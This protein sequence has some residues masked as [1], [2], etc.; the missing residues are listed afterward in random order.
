MKKCIK[1]VGV[2]ILTGIMALSAF[3]FGG[4]DFNSVKDTVKDT[5][6]DITDSITNTENESVKPSYDGTVLTAGETYDFGASPKM[7]F[8]SAVMPMSDETGTETQ[9][10]ETISV[11]VKATVTP[12]D[13]NQNVSWR[14]AF[15]NPE[16]EWA[17][18]KTVTDY[19]EVTPTYE[20]ST[21]ATLSCK[22]SFGE[23]IKLVC[24]SVE[25]AEISASVTVD[26]IRSIE[27]QSLTYGDNLPIN[28]GGVTDVAWEVST[29]GVGVGGAQNFAYKYSENY[30]I[31][32]EVTT[33]VDLVSPN[34]YHNGND[35]LGWGD[36][37]EPSDDSEKEYKDGYFQLYSAQWKDGI[38]IDDGIRDCG[39]ASFK[40]ITQLQFDRQFLNNTRLSCW[41]QREGN[42]LTPDIHYIFHQ[43]SIYGTYTIEE[44]SLYT[45][46]LRM[47]HSATGEVVEKMSLINVTEFTSNAQ[48]AS[49]ALSGNVVY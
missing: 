45:L 31:A 43:G 18:G 20:G 27:L 9:E 4:C 24:T 5:V 11:T 36:Y 33:V 29:N 22:N 12:Y 15:V 16:S 46:R 6:N 30:T 48:V 13:A 23:Q 10:F 21:T 40:N 7:A 42:T 38:L 14:V 2:G 19:V 26:F 49:V 25:N 44:G 47:T 1:K 41:W 34:W 3:A 39:V 28:F 32:N 37:F 35:L 8:C 17:T